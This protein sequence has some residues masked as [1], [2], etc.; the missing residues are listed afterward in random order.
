MAGAVDFDPLGLS[1]TMDI[2]WLRE[3][4]IK[5]GRVAMLATLGYTLPEVFG[6]KFPGFQEDWH[7]NPLKAADAMPPSVWYKFIVSIG[8]VEYL[9]YYGKPMF[10]GRQ[11]GDTCLRNLQS[12]ASRSRGV[13]L[14]PA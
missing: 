13:W 11:P 2:R 12:I 9:S 14:R 7:A 4:E 3:A 1:T 5:H 10:E 6:L 8:F